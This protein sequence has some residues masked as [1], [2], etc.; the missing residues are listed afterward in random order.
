MNLENRELMEKLLD[1]AKKAG[2]DGADV[3][4][5]SGKSLS[6]SAQEGDID[7][8][9][10]SGSKI[11]GIRVIKN[12][13]V[14]ISYTEAFD[15]EALSDTAKKAVE[16]SS[17]GEENEFETID[18]Y[19]EDDLVHMGE[20]EQ[21]AQEDISTE[22][23]IATCLKLESEVKSKDE[24]VKGVPYNG[25][26]EASVE[27]YYLN[28]LGAFCYDFEHY[29][30]AYT[31]SLVK[32][33]DKSSM[34]Y[35]GTIGK[36]FNQLDWR[37]CVEESFQ[38]SIN[39][40]KAEP[41]KTGSYDVIFSSDEFQSLFGAFRG[42]FSAKKAQEKSHPLID[43]LGKTLATEELTIVDSPMY[44]KS[45]FKSPFDSEGY[46]RKD[47]TLVENGVFKNL[48][49]N[50]A[51]S[52][53]FGIENTCRA[54][55]S[56]KSALG[57]GGTTTVIQPG[58]KS[59]KALKEGEYFEVYQM[60]GLHSGLNFMS[61]D[62]SFGASGYL[63]KNGERIRPINGVTVAGNFYK[64][65]NEVAGIGDEILSSSGKDFFSPLIRFSSLKVAGN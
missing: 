26:S 61:G 49:H 42:V 3:V 55:R 58:K 34:Y 47:V 50:S 60:Q 27:G 23:K 56:A 28:S 2:A 14:G 64:M 17:F 46:V 54:A 59:D 21:A 29:V 53:Y 35:H 15:D 52:K 51:T 38:H 11:A 6:M 37:K 7:T 48:L 44:E 20:V 13:K 43:K 8:Y 5:S 9:K 36:H 40:L 57:V 65:L 33:G 16:N 32:E 19:I 24:R 25:L 18:N 63:C 22:E 45:F 62:F 10:V 41:L 1:R 12:N 30:S 31:S 4:F 39:W